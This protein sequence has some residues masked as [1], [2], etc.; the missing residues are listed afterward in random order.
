MTEPL[1]FPYRS[2]LWRRLQALGPPRWTPLADAAVAASLRD[3]EALGA[4]ALADLSP[5]PRLGFKGRDTI[6]AVRER[7]VVAEPVPNRAFRQPDGGLCLVLGPG[8]V[9]LLGPLSGDGARLTDLER[10]WPDGSGARVYPLPRRHS[11]AWVAVAGTRAPDLFA[12]LCAVD[13]R[14]AKFADLSVAQTSVARLNAVLARADLGAV[15]V[16][17]L[18][19]DSA[20]AVYLFDALVDAGA[21]FGVAPVG[22]DVLRA[23]VGQD[24]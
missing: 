5:L 19:A 16:F 15:P 21:E 24:G 17:H 14:P 18:L 8:E 7:G 22:M 23:A 6:R 3:G 9:F 1:A 11:H 10:A 4:L 20:A 2:P 13:L 12:K